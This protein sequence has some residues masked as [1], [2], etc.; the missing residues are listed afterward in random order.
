MV[1]TFHTQDILEAP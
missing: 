1:T